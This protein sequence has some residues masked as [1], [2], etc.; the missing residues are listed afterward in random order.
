[1]YLASS[2]KFHRAS[3]IFVLK[4]DHIISLLCCYVPNK[5]CFEKFIKCA[6]YDPVCILSNLQ[7]WPVLR[8]VF[9]K[10]KKIT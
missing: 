8:R 10:L 1:M 3:Q 9:S 4:T 5:T 2:L 6:V 7:W